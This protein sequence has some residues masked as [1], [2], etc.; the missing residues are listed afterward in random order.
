MARG[1]RAFGGR[2]LDQRL[3]QFYEARRPEGPDTLL[4]DGHIHYWLL[5]F[6]FIFLTLRYLDPLGTITPSL[7]P[8]QY[9]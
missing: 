8:L 4:L 1:A 9:L 5:G 2:H 6:N 7:V 3:G